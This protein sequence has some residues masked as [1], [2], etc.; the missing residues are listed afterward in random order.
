MLSKQS[1]PCLIFDQL[2]NDICSSLEYPVD[3]QLGER[4]PMTEL[5]DLLFNEIIFQDIHWKWMDSYFN[6]NNT[7][8]LE[9]NHE[10][11]GVTT[12]WLIKCSLY[13]KADFMLSNPFANHLLG[14]LVGDFFL[15]RWSYIRRLACLKFWL[16]RLSVWGRCGFLCRFCFL[17]FCVFSGFGRRI[18]EAES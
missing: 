18:C 1:F 9:M 3:I 4:L 15:I 2:P 13:E 5:L 7:E 16:F 14:L 10:V 17:L 11:I 12:P 6:F 8:G